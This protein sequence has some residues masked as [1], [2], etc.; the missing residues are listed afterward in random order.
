MLTTC[1]CCGVLSGIAKG[2]LYGA[3]FLDQLLP[4]LS[5]GYNA[6][7][8]MC[9][10]RQTTARHLNNSGPMSFPFGVQ[11]IYDEK[12][13]PSLQPID[14]THGASKL[15]HRLSVLLMMGSEAARE[16]ARHGGLEVE[17]VLE[18]GRSP[19]KSCAHVDCSDTGAG[20]RQHGHIPWGSKRN[21]V[22]YVYGDEG[23]SDGSHAGEDLWHM[24]LVIS[25][26]L[27][28]SETQSILGLD[29]GDATCI[30]MQPQSEVR[31]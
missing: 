24:V 9:L 31:P 26:K 11:L 14:P 23:L 8:A 20:N 5:M 6:I 28:Q 3:A 16:V 30:F 22:K 4:I 12:G 7:D 10:S 15:F 29:P 25:Y 18:A 2:Q 13:L 19:G 27:T 21:G 1:A 17:T